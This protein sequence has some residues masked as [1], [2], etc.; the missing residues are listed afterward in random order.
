MN[1]SLVVHSALLRSPFENSAHE[2]PVDSGN[3][4]RPTRPARD[5]GAEKDHVRALGE[6]R[7]QRAHPGVLAD[8]LG[9]AGERRLRGSQC[10]GLGE[11]RVG[12]ETRHGVGKL[13]GVPGLGRVDDLQVSGYGISN[14]LPGSP[15]S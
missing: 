3:D 10:R 15:L 4:N 11:A 7:L 2:R 14:R 1:A 6:R 9:L 5:A 13:L 12:R 8:R